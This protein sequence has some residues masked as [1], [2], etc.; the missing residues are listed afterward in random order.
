MTGRSLKVKLK[1][2]KKK[3]WHPL[4]SLNIKKNP[5]F[6]SDRLVAIA[7][8]LLLTYKGKSFF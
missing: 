7:F 6:T 8:V 1:E 4:N 3:A 5:L 2:R